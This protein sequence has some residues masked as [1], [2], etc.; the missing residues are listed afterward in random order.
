M[1]QEGATLRSRTDEEL[2]DILQTVADLN[3]Q[4]RTILTNEHITLEEARQLSH[5]IT[6]MRVL[7]DELGSKAGRLYRGVPVPAAFGLMKELYWEL[8][9]LVKEVRNNLDRK[10]VAFVQGNRRPWLE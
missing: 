5:S 4:T 6:Q 2:R 10:K 8:E 3:N 9:G 7:L 1:A